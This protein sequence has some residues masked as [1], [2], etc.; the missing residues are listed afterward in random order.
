MSKISFP[1]VKG[2]IEQIMDDIMAAPEIEGLPAD[3]NFSLRLAIE[4][5]A[6]NVVNYA[7]PEGEDGNL[8]V[9]IDLAE[10]M[11]SITLCDH[12][13][14]FNPLEKEDPDVTLSAEDRAI[15]GLGIFL[16]KQLMDSVE[17][18]YADGQNQLKICKNV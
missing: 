6:A 7:Y 2:Q 16:V 1:T 4:E 8:N 15:G 10:N 17:Y 9:D 13:I 11:L 12:G 14:P 5:L 3:L 18:R